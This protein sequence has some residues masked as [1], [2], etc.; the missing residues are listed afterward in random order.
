[1]FQ[2]ITTSLQRIA[3]LSPEQ[4]SLLFHR[5]KTL[6]IK[7][8]GYLIKEGQTCQSLCFLNHGSFRH[9]FVQEN[10]EEATLNLFIETDWL[11][12]YKS[13]ITQ[14]PSQ[15]VIQAVTDSEVFSLSIWDFHALARDS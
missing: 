2:Q 5:L 1:M 7:K 8:D 15:N 13:F 3:R 12:E 9:Y 10:G 11:F 14:K 4:L 6:H